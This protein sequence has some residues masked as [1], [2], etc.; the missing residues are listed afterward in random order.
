[1]HGPIKVKSPNNI[2]KWQMKFN[3]AFKGLIM[4]ARPI[5]LPLF[6]GRVDFEAINVLHVGVN[7]R[8]VKFKI[9]GTQNK[10]RINLLYK[11]ILNPVTISANKSIHN[12]NPI[13][14]YSLH[15]AQAYTCVGI[16]LAA[17]CSKIKNDP[18]L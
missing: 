7:I 18:T 15:F 2:S 4:T 9:N 1:M 10:L 3:S 8:P 11:I 13:H 6:V 5:F 17:L 14:I 12:N 16:V